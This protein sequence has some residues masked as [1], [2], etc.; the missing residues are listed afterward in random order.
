MKKNIQLS[1][2]TLKG[3]A[4]KKIINIKCNK[5]PKVQINRALNLV[6]LYT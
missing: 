2:I 3:L 5:T 6:L 1:R 4:N